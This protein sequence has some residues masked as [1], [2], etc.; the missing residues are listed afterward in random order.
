MTDN[1]CAQILVIVL[2]FISNS[3]FI[4][5]KKIKTDPLAIIPFICILICIL[6]ILVFSLS[7]VELL[8]LII[9][10]FCAIWNVRSLLRMSA[11]LILDQ[12]GIKFK[13]ISMINLVLISWLAYILFHYRPCTPKLKN[14]H[15]KQTIEY[16][17]GDLKKGFK[18]IDKPFT[19]VNA[20]LYKIEHE[21]AKENDINEKKTIV[22]FVPG[23]A[24]DTENYLTL[25][26][27]LAMHNITV[28]AADFYTDDGDWFSS[29]G[30]SKPFRKFFM[31]N[32]KLHNEK[33]FADKINSNKLYFI[34]QFESLYK[35]ASPGPNDYVF[36][37]TDNDT[38]G[39]MKNVLEHH[40]DS[41]NFICGSYD[42]AFI[43]GYKTKDFGPVENSDPLL[44]AKL[45]IGFDRSGYW[46]SHMGSVVIKHI[47]SILKAGSD[48]PSAQ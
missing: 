24:A 44:A 39:A 22:L 33:E 47:Q 46:S 34:R 1:L 23:I 43:D 21:N 30:N 17:S 48:T 38:T 2:L 18:K 40:T 25:L 45:K 16:Y 13:I 20:T 42:L 35:L 36:L 9:S 8:L 11:G 28:Y 4:F 32:D 6:N 26:Y 15:A 14:F 12:Y 37:L 10:I 3:R 7:F 31:L 27:K 29:L 5:I 19:R 41:N